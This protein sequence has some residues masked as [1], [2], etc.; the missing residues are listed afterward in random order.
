MET[1]LIFLLDRERTL[2]DP[3]SRHPARLNLFTALPDDRRD[4]F[5]TRNNPGRLGMQHE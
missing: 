3:F 2:A 5:G 1:I 4:G